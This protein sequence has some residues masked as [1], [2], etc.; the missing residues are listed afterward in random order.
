MVDPTSDV[1]EDTEGST[2]TCAT[3]GEKIINEPSHRVLT[4]IE[5]TGVT[6]VHFCNEECLSAFEE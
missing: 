2:P 4:H 5:D 1:G 6:T 3:C